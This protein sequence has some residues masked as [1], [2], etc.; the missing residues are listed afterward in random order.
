VSISF[1]RLA[2][3]YLSSFALAA[4]LFLTIQAVCAAG[5]PGRNTAAM[6]AAD[7]DGNFCVLPAESSRATV[8][9]FVLHDCPVCNRYVPEIN[10]LTEDYKASNVATYIVYDESDLTPPQARAHS[11][12]YGLTCGLLYDPSHKLAHQLGVTA[13]PEA[14]LLSPSG[15]VVYL[16][17]IDDSFK[18]FG[19]ISRQPTSHDLRDAL[20]ALL[21]GKTVAV[22]RTPVVGCA[23]APD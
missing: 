2:L 9:I 14:V 19:M 6:S 3:S 12:A 13:A 17:R 16:G 15:D 8:L 20:D 7:L 1:R 5:F 4:S 10:R 18:H 21:A 23:I 22:A 11:K